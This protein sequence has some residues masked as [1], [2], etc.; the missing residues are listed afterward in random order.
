MIGAGLGFGPLPTHVAERSVRRGKLWRLPPYENTLAIDIHLVHHK[1]ARLNRAERA[2]LDMFQRRM[3]SVSAGR[4][5]L[6]PGKGQLTNGTI[7]EKGERIPMTS[8]DTLSLLACQI[9]IPVTESAAA[10]DRHLAESAAKVRDQLNRRNMD[11]VVLPELSS[12]DYSRAAFDRLDEISEPLQGASFAVWRE[13]AMEFGVHVSYSFAR[14]GQSGTFISIAVV[15]PDGALVGHYDKLHLCQ[16]GASM[17]KEYFVGGDHI[18]TF[19]VNGP[20]DLADHMLRYP[21]SR[22][23]ADVDPEARR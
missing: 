2:M 10:R 22:T 21:H 15:G 11:L 18:F 20:D 17:E 13:V 1:N 9:E 6:E 5:Q 8:Q 3:A 16:Y 12:I 7:V 19:K 14:K 23:R 4:A